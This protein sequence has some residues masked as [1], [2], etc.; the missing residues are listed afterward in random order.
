M[1]SNKKFLLI[2]D[3][4]INNLVCK[5]ILGGYGID[6]IIY[7]KPSEA[8]TS[9]EQMSRDNYDLILL[10][11]NMPQIDGWEFIEKC[12]SI[13]VEKPICIITSSVDSRDKDKAKQYSEVKEFIVKPLTPQQALI[14]RNI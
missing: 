10:D 5:Q 4:P 12:R 11:I 7:E 6:V 3:D 8:L 13:N 14:L 2:D 1:N 9:L